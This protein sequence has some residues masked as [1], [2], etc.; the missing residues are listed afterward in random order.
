[1]QRVGRGG[2]CVAWGTAGLADQRPAATAPEGGIGVGPPARFP[3]LRSRRPHL[4]GHPRPL[5][6]FSRMPKGRRETGCSVRDEM[7]VRSGCGLPPRR[8]EDDCRELLAGR[9]HAGRPALQRVAVLGRVAARRLLGQLASARRRPRALLLLLRLLQ[10][11]LRLEDLA[12]LPRSAARAGGRTSSGR[13][14]GRASERTSRSGMSTTDCVFGM[15]S[16]GAEFDRSVWL[17]ADG[18]RRR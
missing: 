5:R 13:A 14:Q 15:R 2:S 18:E 10:L 4:E 9:G 11:Q 6:P 3:K 12:H 17:G 16:A 7:S 1:M 8:T